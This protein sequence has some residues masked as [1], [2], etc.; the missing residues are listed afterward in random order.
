MFVFFLELLL[1]GLDWS[2]QPFPSANW[3][4]SRRELQSGVQ[5]VA[6]N[7]WPSQAGASQGPDSFPSSSKGP[8]LPGETNTWPSA[9]RCGISFIYFIPHGVEGHVNIIP[10]TVLLQRVWRHVRMCIYSLLRLHLGH[11]H[12]SGSKHDI[13]C[14]KFRRK[15]EE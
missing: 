5:Q 6:A 4:M 8:S 15:H 11:H 12:R 14:L 3:I 1:T 7:S 9:P 13:H 2:A 10:R